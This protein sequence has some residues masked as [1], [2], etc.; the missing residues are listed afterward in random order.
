MKNSIY[1]RLIKLV[2]NYW[3]FLALSTAA[4]F[5]YVALNGISVWLTASLINNILSDFDKLILEQSKLSSS[6]ILTL[7]EKIKYFTNDLI[8]RGSAKETLQM[9]CYSILTIFVL[10]NVFLYLKNVSLIVVQYRLITEL[11]NKLYIH[12]HTLSLSFFNN[13]K[14]GE[15]TS[16]IVND[17][18]N[19]RQALTIGFQR[20]FVEPIN[21][22]AF[23]TLLFILFVDF[24][25]LLA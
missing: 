18:A 22:I 17:V 15:L 1:K 10:K 13:Q 4:A 16:I 2:F 24:F 19:M 20:M 25:H 14:S 11:R 3:P 8:L 21:I 6:T 7:N 5:F 9:L 12:F 23:T